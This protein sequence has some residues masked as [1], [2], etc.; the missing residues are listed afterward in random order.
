[1]VSNQSVVDFA[2]G[3]RVYCPASKGVSP[4]SS[5][6]FERVMKSH[7]RM[8]RSFRHAGGAGFHRATQV[9]SLPLPSE[10]SRE[11]STGDGG[12]GTRLWPPGCEA[13]LGTAGYS[14]IVVPA[15]Q[16]Q[17]HSEEVVQ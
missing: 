11:G 16:L 12:D 14:E 13:A 8:D 3:I 9:A 4:P 6:T 17:R 7:W 1:M 5:G 10:A 15:P 2:D